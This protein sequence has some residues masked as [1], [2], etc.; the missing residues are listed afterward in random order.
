M[1]WAFAVATRVAGRGTRDACADACAAVDRPVRMEAILAHNSEHQVAVAGCDELAKQLRHLACVQPPCSDGLHVPLQPNAATFPTASSV[2][3][4]YYWARSHGSA[5]AE[6]KPRL[7][8]VRGTL[9][10]GFRSPLRAKATL[11]HRCNT[12]SRISCPRL[13]PPRLPGCET[14]A[15]SSRPRTGS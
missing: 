12:R 2:A 3:D 9:V 11:R 6:P 14:A 1:R 13:A 5:S 8:D 7:P 15:P 4:R 10:L